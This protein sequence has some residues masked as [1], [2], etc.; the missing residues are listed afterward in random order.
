MNY[1]EHKICTVMHEMLATE[2]PNTLRYI[3]QSGAIHK[4]RDFEKNA[5][6]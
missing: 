3:L 1:L 6:F 2:D 4:A 5:G